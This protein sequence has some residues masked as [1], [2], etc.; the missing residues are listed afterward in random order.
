[1]NSVETEHLMGLVRA[2]RDETGCAVVIVDHDLHFIMAVCERVYVMNE[3]R[4]IAAGTPAEVQRDPAVV[5]AYLG[6]RAR[7][8]AEETRGESPAQLS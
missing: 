4:L 7:N 3:G 6:T 5:K 2:L 8:R 1:M